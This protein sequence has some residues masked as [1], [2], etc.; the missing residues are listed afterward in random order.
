M[1]LLRAVPVVLSAGERTTLNKRV[2]GA[3]TAHRDRLRAQIVLAAARGRDNV[4][5]AADL[6]ISA[7]TVRKWRGRFARRGLDGLADLPRS[8]RPRRISELTRAAVVAL[9]CQLPAATG[10]PLSRWTGPELLAEVTR[11]GTKDALSASSVLRILAE[12]PVKPWQYRSWIYPRDPDFEAKATVILDLYQGF[13]QGKRLRPGDRILSADA[14]PSIQARGRC[15]PLPRPR[16]AS[17]CDSSMNTSAMALS[18]CWP[19]STYA[20]GKCSPPPRPPPASP[21]SWT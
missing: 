7:D 14:K 21:P 12:H 9:A 15:H 17:P 11:A 8:G 1:P 10:V 16:P 2:R 3:K 5:I 13:Y 18:P 6:R 4:R 19:R 20:P